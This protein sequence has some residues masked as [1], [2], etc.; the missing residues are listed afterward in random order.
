[1]GVTAFSFILLPLSL[2]WF[3]QP[4]RLLQ[5]L[6]VSSIFEAAAA[7]TIGSLGVQP[8]LVPALAF[9]AFTSLQLLLGRRY[10]GQ[11]QAW[12]MSRPFVLVAAWAIAG[13]YAMPR[14]FEGK[15]YVWPQ[16]GTLPYAITL[17][18]PTAT[19]LNQDFY[20]L[21]NTALFVLAA[22]FLTKSKISLKSLMHA[23]FLSGFA[24]AAVAVWQ[25]GNRVAGLPYP[26]SLFYSNPGWA[27]L[28]EQ[29]IGAVPR[30][31]G[32]FSEPAAL[33]GYMAAAVCSTGWLILQ[34]NR[35]VIIRLLFVVGL[36]TVMLSTSTT[37][38]GV[39]AVSA[40]GVVLYALV[41]GSKRLI[42]QVVRIGVPVLLLAGFMF[43]VA[44]ALAP[45]LITSVQDVFETV[46][47]KQESSSY[48]DR[49]SADVD[50]L[51]AMVDTYGFG[52]G[53][54]INRSSSLVPGLLAGI[55]VPG[56]LGLVW[57]GAALARQVRKLRLLGCSPDQ[58]L[59][60]DGCCGAL[61]GFLVG[62][63]ISAPTLTSVTFFF[64]LAL[65]IGCVARA[66]VEARTRRTNV[67]D[68]VIAL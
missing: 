63:V 25:L 51:D 5:M 33:G 49:T 32:T 30:I 15:A 60:I 29:Q 11:A 19:N 55:G 42:A 14:M 23:Y 13:S 53:W 8:G 44:S 21:L 24:A 2:L 50:S 39:L 26:E 41:S 4:M 28:T 12:R 59:V 64:L 54:G 40:A 16:K 52:V 1:M 36:L 9:I 7:V 47:N 17:L 35:D 10:P 3:Q 27:I 61:V 48:Q 43:V 45:A 31:N 58:M 20:L 67:R 62:A 18:E 37:G 38:F 56:V 68:S 57:F 46:V 65:L 66:Q 6:L 34:G 22:M